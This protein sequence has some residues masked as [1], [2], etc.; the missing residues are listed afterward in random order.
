MR[1]GSEITVHLTW[2]MIWAGAK[3]F[4]RLVPDDGTLKDP[5]DIVPVIFAEMMALCPGV[6]VVKEDLVKPFVES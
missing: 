6:S 2:E 3:A 4:E 5:T 1:Q